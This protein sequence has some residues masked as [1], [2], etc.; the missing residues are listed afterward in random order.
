MRAPGKAG[1]EDTVRPSQGQE[2]KGADAAKSTARAQGLKG[3]LGMHPPRSGHPKL[4]E[5]LR[6]NNTRVCKPPG[7][8]TSD[9]RG[10][11]DKQLPAP[12]PQGWLEI[13][14]L[15]IEAQ[16]VARRPDGKVVFVDGALPG[17]L[18][19]VNVH[20]KKNNWE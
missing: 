5:T 16:G 4:L 17:E 8:R 15:D 20:R 19:T 6:K 14:S 2:K 9:N 13:E 10:M 1:L 3:V 7:L 11:T 18:V 12:H